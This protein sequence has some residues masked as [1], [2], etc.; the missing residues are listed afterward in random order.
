MTVCVK[1]SS[2]L[3]LCKSLSRILLTEDVTRVSH[4]C[5]S[6]WFWTSRGKTEHVTVYSWLKAP[7]FTVHRWLSSRQFTNLNGWVA[8]RRRC[9]LWLFRSSRAVKTREAA[10]SNR[11]TQ[12]ISYSQMCIGYRSRSRKVGTLHLLRGSIILTHFFFVFSAE[13]YIIV[14]WYTVNMW[15]PSYPMKCSKL[16]CCRRHSASANIKF[17]SNKE[18]MSQWLETPLGLHTGVQ[19]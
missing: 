9:G 5:E 2:K 10:L 14:I 8:L 17:I 7:F 15:N 4:R 1:I 11:N 18:V 19:V 16:P 6:S 12:K 13:T 3:Q